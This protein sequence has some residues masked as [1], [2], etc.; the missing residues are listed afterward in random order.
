V[1]VA[2]LFHPARDGAGSF[3]TLEH[4]RV[5]RA[6]L[7]PGGGFYQWLPLYQLDLDTLRLITRT[8]LAAIPEGTAFLAHYRL[9][10]PIVGLAARLGVTRYPENWFRVRWRRTKF[11]AAEY[12]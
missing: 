3:Y 11:L 4:F 12:C 8:F 9:R 5:I 10:A 2:D 7:S 6:L 1:I